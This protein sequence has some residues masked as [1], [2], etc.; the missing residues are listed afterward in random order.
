MNWFRDANKIFDK[1]NWNRRDWLVS[2]EAYEFLKKYIGEEILTI[3]YSPGYI[4]PHEEFKDD[5]VVLNNQVE[6][7]I[8]QK[9][10][11]VPIDQFVQ[12][13]RAVRFA[14]NRLD[15]N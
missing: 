9:N 4:F 15:Q 6:M 1:N 10:V 2:Q 12:D 7:I 5:N 14:N 11:H 13:F 8:V 3:R